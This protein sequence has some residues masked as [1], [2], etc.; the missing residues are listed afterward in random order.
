M[1]RLLRVAVVATVVAA[2]GLSTAGPASAVMTVVVWPGQSIQAAVDSAP[3]GGTVVIKPGHYQQSVLVRRGDVEVRGSGASLS[4]TVIEPSS[5]T[6]Q[7][8][9]AQNFS[10]ICV[11]NRKDKINRLANVRINNLMVHN[12]PGDGVIAFFTKN[13]SVENVFAANN[14]EYGIARF[15][16]VG[17]QLITNTTTGSG[18]AGLYVGDSLPANVFV[19]GNKSYDN[20]WGMLYR[21]ARGADIEFNDFHDNCIGVL[22]IAAPA[23]VGNALFANNTV[24]HN[25]KFCAGV[26]DE[27]PFDMQGGGVALVGTS[28]VLVEHNAIYNNRG[29]TLLSG[30]VVL[31]SAK[32][33]GG[34]VSSGNTIRN[35]TLFGD[36]PA[37]IV[38]HSGGVN[39]IRGNFCTRSIPAGFCN[40]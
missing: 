33:F 22:M 23:P 38:D 11:F 3:I 37:D 27:V 24:R 6:S 34:P 10:G 2:S 25:N 29:K 7:N 26:P 13:L 15:D 31:Q 8:F 5:P 36:A 39:T 28:G 30:G 21:H 12:F 18:E 40:N 17:G 20:Q 4:G 35:N 9:C 16:S 32:P 14:G 1:K 19:A